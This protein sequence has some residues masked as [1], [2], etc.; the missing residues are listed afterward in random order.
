MSKLIYTGKY[1]DTFPLKRGVEY[2]VKVV[3]LPKEDSDEIIVSVDGLYNKCYRSLADFMRFW[4]RP[5]FESN[6]GGY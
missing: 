1:F 4:D 5:K 2:D 6:Y 3:Y